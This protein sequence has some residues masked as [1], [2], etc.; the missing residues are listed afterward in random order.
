MSIPYDAV[1]IG[2]GPAGSSAAILLARAGWRVA[3]IEKQTFPRRKVCGECIAASNLPLLDALGIGAD[4]AASA[5][6]A[7]R[8]V[9]LM[10][11]HQSVTAPL[12]AAS[13]DG[14]RH[15][16]AVGRETLDTR[17]LEAARRAGVQVFQPWAVEAIDG[18]PGDW[19]C[20]MR[21]V[22]SDQRARLKAR[23][24]IDAH[25]SWEALSSARQ[26]RRAA[27]RSSD[28]FAFKANFHGSTLAPGALA[29]LAFD[30]GY[31]GMVLA[32]GGVT[33]VACCIRRDRLKSSRAQLP[34][35]DA[36]EA[37]EAY[38]NQQCSGV[39]VALADA[40]RDGPWLASG[41]IKPGIR[42]HGADE[43]FRIGNAAGEAHPIIGEGMSMALQSAWLLCGRLIDPAQRDRP[44]GSGRQ[45]AIGAGLPIEW[46]RHFGWRLRLASVFAHAAMRPGS[47]VMLMG[48]VQH[49][50]GLLVAGARWGGKIT[51]AV[52]EGTVVSLSTTDGPSVERVR[53]AAARPS[54]RVFREET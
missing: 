28:L 51:S 36:G 53:G 52:D 8:Q 4:I 9:V 33:T 26:A 30:G 24:A 44:P 43:P 41:P 38:L 3:L 7:L 37:V 14:H 49:W 23:V 10:R 25:G 39:R 46:R 22:G 48:L 5:G 35:L 29:V 40:R 1:V 16:V 15:G 50:P 47:A 34:G 27:H 45:H 20:G 12:P 18:G 54:S 2:A 19:T 11:A 21:A 31:G 6:P 42:V 17:L 13:F 32:G